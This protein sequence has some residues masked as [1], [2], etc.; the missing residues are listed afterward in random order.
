MNIFKNVKLSRI[1]LYLSAILLVSIVFIYYFRLFPFF[2]FTLNQRNGSFMVE[3]SYQI[4]Q[5]NIFIYFLNWIGII[6]TALAFFMREKHFGNIV[7]ILFLVGSTMFL[8]KESLY[9]DEINFFRENILNSK[10]TTDKT[11][12]INQV[13]IIK[14]IDK[15]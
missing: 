14:E 15:K 7:S 6:C 10:I 11:S 8:T 4:A 1:N 13:E 3:E 2:E 9:M 5:R 12:Y